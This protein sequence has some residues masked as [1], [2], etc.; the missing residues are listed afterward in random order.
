MKKI[1][2]VLIALVCIHFATAKNGGGNTVKAA[3]NAVTVYRTGA[4]LTHQAKAQ[5]AAGNN[6]LVIENISNALDP[7][8]IQVNCDGNVTVMGI[9]FST[10]YLKEE[11]K[12]PTVRLLEDSVE[13]ISRE[14]DKT[15][16]SL[17]IVND[18]I[19][20][21]KANKEIKGTQTGLS[22]AEL[23]KL[24][25][26]Y[27]T[28][29]GELQNEL[30]A[31]NQQQ[32]KQDKQ[33]KKLNEQIA[34]E[35]NRNTK[36]AGKLIL[37][38]SCAIAGKYDFNIS[39]VTQ[40]AYWTPFY[41]LRA[42]NIA[43]PL[44]IVYRAKIFQTTGIDWKQVKLSLST[45]TPTQ[46]GNAPLFK[47]WFLSYINPVNFYNNTLAMENTI[48]GLA[49]RVPGL[50]LNEVE[51]TGFASKIKVRGLN[52]ITSDTAPLYIV[53]GS[54]MS[55]TDFSKINA[56]AVKNIEV[57]KDA[58]AINLY[59]TRASNGVIVITFK[60]GLDDYITVSDKE[61]NVIFDIDLPYDV[62]T[63]GKAQTA[64]LKE[65]EV[66]A[67]YQ[68]YAVPKLDKEVFLLAQITD[69]EKLNL[70]PG[71][72][73]IIFEGT[74]IG[75]SFIDPSSTQDTLNLTMGRDKRVVV[76]REKLMDFSSVKFLGANKKQTFTYEITVK[77]NKKEAINILLKDQYPLSQNKEIEV[78]LVESDGAAVNTET[79]VLNWKLQLAAG[80]SKKVRM[81]YSVKYPKDKLLNL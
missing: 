66:P 75:K 11:V 26:Y 69:W 32:V 21:L 28:K 62:P 38:L 22:V 36:S 37:Q 57:L 50:S 34:E 61:L 15:R 60:D 49:G 5:L 51:A 40:N 14:L 43:S 64:V 9:E 4:E 44:K 77:N 48:T 24:M 30:A 27:K 35:Q 79:G 23:M 73:N 53:N 56:N 31:L 1:S 71:E 45:S 6:E 13:K 39:Y 74:Y 29:S 2:L 59:G 33:L 65:Y 19:S 52:S 81:S 17:N 18:L 10:D 25:E 70:M 55:A 42:A 58:A 41:D 78:E 76:K 63:N 46:T 16:S 80:E 7:N 3:L 47:T 67:T 54:E 20:V 8:S 12:S 72:A 68:F